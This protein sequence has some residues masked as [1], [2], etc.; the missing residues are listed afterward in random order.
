VS[1]SP[2]LVSDDFDPSAVKVIGGIA[3][4]P[5]T[6]PNVVQLEDVGTMFLL[7]YGFLCSSY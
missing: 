4:E 3:P 2:P 6:T 5:A 1:R 7:K